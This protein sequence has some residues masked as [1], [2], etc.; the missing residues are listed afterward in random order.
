MAIPPQ[1]HT[2]FMVYGVKKGKFNYFTGLDKFL[3]CLVALECGFLNVTMTYHL[4]V[5]NTYPHAGG[6]WVVC[7]YA[8][9]Q[10]GRAI[11]QAI[12]H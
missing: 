11:S 2:N 12:K 7:I 10:M 1:W 9:T 5:S 3:R 6:V 8:L 4:T